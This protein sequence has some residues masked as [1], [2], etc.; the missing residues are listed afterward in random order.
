MIIGT[1]TGGSL[2]ADRDE[3]GVKCC[4][5]LGPVRFVCQRFTFFDPIVPTLSAC[6]NRECVGSVALDAGAKEKNKFILT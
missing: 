1:D 4:D 2:L 3:P 6:P 5:A